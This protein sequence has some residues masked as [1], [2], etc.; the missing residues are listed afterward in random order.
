MLKKRVIVTLCHDGRGNALKPV[1]FAKHNR[2]KV[3][4]LIQHINVLAKRNI[5]ELVLMDICATEENRGQ[6]LGL[7]AEVCEKLTCPV[8]I[9]GGIQSRQQ[10]KELLNH[11]ADKIILRSFAYKDI[12]KDIS[13][14]I[15]SQSVAIAIDV[16]KPFGK[17]QP[18]DK[19]FLMQEIISYRDAGAGEFIVTSVAHDGRMEGMDIE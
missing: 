6:N 7:V 3:G 1:G 8:A 18:R 11:G 13:N 16:V 15:G 4:S 14:Y 17:L 12:V 2:R 10:V 19:L 5:D 9:G